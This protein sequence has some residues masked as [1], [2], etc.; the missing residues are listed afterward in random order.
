MISPLVPRERSEVEFQS[1]DVVFACEGMDDCAVVDLLTTHWPRKPKIGTRSERVKFGWSEEF[2]AL[3]KQAIM[4]GIRTIGF[5][6]D[7]EPSRH[8]RRTELAR[9]Y[10][11]AKLIMPTDECEFA[12]T[13][14]TPGTTVQTA[15][16]IVPGAQAGCIEDLFMSQV[17]ASPIA[18][19]IEQLMKCYGEE[20]PTA[21]PASKLRLRTFLAHKNAYNTGLNL[22][23]RDKHLHCNAPEFQRL[24]DFIAMFGA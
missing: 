13:P 10:S 18:E 3:K 19:C 14:L 9:W 4:R 22:A 7:A 2:I 12:S 11:A 24:R 16:L 21:Q 6:F 20:Q 23:L 15:Y 17:S 1:G 8:A 5:L